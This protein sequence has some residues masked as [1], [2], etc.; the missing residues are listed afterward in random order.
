MYTWNVALQPI[1]TLPGIRSCDN[2]PDTGGPRLYALG[3][4]DAGRRLFV[5]FAV[6]EELI[7]II[8]ARDMSRRERKVYADAEK[9]EKDTQ[10]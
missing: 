7:R 6:R 4:T 3:Q 8:S 5:V 2:Y 10:V 9:E 1:K